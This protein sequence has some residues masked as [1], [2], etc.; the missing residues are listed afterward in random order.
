MSCHRVCKFPASSAPE[1]TKVG[2]SKPPT[3]AITIAN[4]GHTEPLSAGRTSLSVDGTPVCAR[5]HP[6]PQRQIFGQTLE[7]LTTNSGFRVFPLTSLVLEGENLCDFASPKSSSQPIGMQHPLR[8]RALLVW[9]VNQNG[10]YIRTTAHKLGLPLSREGD[11]YVAQKPFSHSRI[12]H[13]SHSCCWVPGR[14]AFLY[15]CVQGR[16]QR[17]LLKRNSARQLWFARH[18]NVIGVD[19]FRCGRPLHLRR[20]GQPHRKAF[21]TNR[22]KQ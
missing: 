22:R 2:A 18:G 9:N 1:G 6:N 13:S 4:G 11:E 16:G 15:D 12:I 19:G 20:K 21:R 10:N 7:T 17:I 8:R 5:K 14:R 3:L